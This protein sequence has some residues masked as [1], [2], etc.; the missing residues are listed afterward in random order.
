MRA[1]DADDRRQTEAAPGLLGGEEG[2]EDVAIASGD[3]PQPVS[4]TSRLAYRPAARS[5][6]STGVVT[7]SG[8][9]EV[10]P[11]RTTTVPGAPPSASAALRIRFIATCWSWLGSARTGVSTSSP[12]RTSSQVTGSVERKSGASDETSSGNET[13]SV[14]IW[15]LP[16]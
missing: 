14:T 5:L 4:S 11:V 3:M 15:S 2:I 8:S 10:T 13:T 16:A 1:H 7:A 6:P 9:N 12:S